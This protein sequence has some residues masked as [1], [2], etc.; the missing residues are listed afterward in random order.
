MLCA[1]YEVEWEDAVDAIT[2]KH[3]LTISHP[4]DPMGCSAIDWNCNGVVIGAGYCVNGH[5]SWCTHKAYVAMVFL[6]LPA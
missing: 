5:S 3:T 2:C 4:L 6:H 1:G